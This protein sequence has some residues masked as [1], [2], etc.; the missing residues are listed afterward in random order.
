MLLT[1]AD[2]INK[3]KT[4]ITILPKATEAGNPDFRVMLRLC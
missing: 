1:Y 2:S 4:D 3:K